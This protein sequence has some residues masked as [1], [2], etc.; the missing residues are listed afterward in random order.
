M[1]DFGGEDKFSRLNAWH[2]LLQ[3]EAVS[4]VLCIRTCSIS[5]VCHLRSFI[6][7]ERCHISHCVVPSGGVFVVCARA[8]LFFWCVLTTPSPLCLSVCLHSPHFLLSSGLVVQK[9]RNSRSRSCWSPSRSTLF[10][11]DFFFFYHFKWN[12]LNCH[13]VSVLSWLGPII[14][15]R[16]S[17]KRLRLSFMISLELMWITWRSGWRLEISQFRGTMKLNY[18]WKHN[19][20]YSWSDQSVASQTVCICLVCVSGVR[21]LVCS[22]L[23][24]TVFDKKCC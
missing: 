17:L 12:D 8:D 13:P 3:F 22:V 21:T 1:M 7:L 20:L 18:L 10:P 6:G 4:R 11:F 19:R 5:A 14:S 24:S 15:M 2:Y 23:T 9:P 16:Q